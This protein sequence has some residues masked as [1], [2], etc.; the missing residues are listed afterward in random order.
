MLV[1]IFKK[2]NPRNKTK[3]QNEKFFIL[4]NLRGPRYEL[5]ILMKSR[6]M[7]R[8]EYLS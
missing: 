1:E 4:E 2:Y 8:I 3:L 7:T 5:N 6:E